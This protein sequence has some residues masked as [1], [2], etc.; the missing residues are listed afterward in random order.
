[1]HRTIAKCWRVPNLKHL[2]QA[3]KASAQAVR[4]TPQASE[5]RARRRDNPSGSESKLSGLDLTL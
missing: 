5:S 4:A 3:S 2:G 1:M